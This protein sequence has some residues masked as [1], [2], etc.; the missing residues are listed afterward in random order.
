M[1]ISPIGL[2]VLVRRIKFF[3]LWGSQVVTDR[4]RSRT[5]ASMWSERVAW[6]FNA[7]NKLASG[8]NIIVTRLGVA[9][10]WPI[11]MFDAL[12]VVTSRSFVV[13]MRLWSTGWRH[14]AT[15][16][17][18]RLHDTLRPTHEKVLDIAYASEVDPVTNYNNFCA[19]FYRAWTLHS[20]SA[21]VLYSYGMGLTVCP[22]GLSVRHSVV[23]F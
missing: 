9:V 19:F 7:L 5:K 21:K 8:R 13:P 20:A 1:S 3:W 18:T 12:A 16:N 22:S 17:Y 15:F 10:T 23:W 14:E 2:L 11:G 6:V 4:W